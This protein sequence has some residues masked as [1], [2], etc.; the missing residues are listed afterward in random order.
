MSSFTAEQK[1]YLEGLFVGLRQRGGGPL[2]L[3][4]SEIFPSKTAEVPSASETMM[5]LGESSP[6]KTS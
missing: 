3:D 5:T 1:E 2:Q 4:F 6:T